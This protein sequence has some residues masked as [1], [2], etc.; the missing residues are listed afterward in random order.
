[1]PAAPAR[2]AAPNTS[3][4]WT[5][6][7]LRIPRLTSWTALRRGR[8]RTVGLGLSDFAIL[9]HS[10][11]ACVIQVKTELDKRTFRD[12]M[13]N[14]ATFKWRGGAIKPALLF[15]Y[16]SAPLTPER[17]D[18]WY[19]AV[20]LPDALLFYPWAVFVLNQGLLYMYRDSAGQWA[21]RMVLGDEGDPPKVRSLSIFLQIFRKALLLHTGDDKNPF[22]LALWDGLRVSTQACRFGKGVVEGPPP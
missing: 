8:N 5:S 11:V 10:A 2:I 9:D 19:K 14:L 1:M 15:A 22:D 6:E 20:D 13:Q 4:G 17:L 16:E 3:R 21:H 7:L 18:E 12:G